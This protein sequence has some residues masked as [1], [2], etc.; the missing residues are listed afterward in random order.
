[1]ANKCIHVS[2]KGQKIDLTLSSVFKELTSHIDMNRENTESCGKR[3][4]IF[5]K[6]SKKKS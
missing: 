1:M 4:E 6:G 5:H 3:S 2:F